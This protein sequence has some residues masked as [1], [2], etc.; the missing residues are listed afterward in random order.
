MK[1]KHCTCVVSGGWYTENTSIFIKLFQKLG[2]TLLLG[3]PEMAVQS[4]ANSYVSADK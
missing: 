1:S 3:D 4:V 2:D